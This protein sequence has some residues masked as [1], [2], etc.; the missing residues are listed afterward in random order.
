MWKGG[1]IQEADG[2]VMVHRPD[3]P[4]ANNKGYVFEHRLVMEAHLG[5]ILDPKEVVHHENEV[6]NDNRLENLKLYPS[7][8]E[9]KREDRARRTTDAAGQFEPKKEGHRAAQG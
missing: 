3:H 7:N 8:A 2:Y 4:R 1:R 5:R 6:R 9:H